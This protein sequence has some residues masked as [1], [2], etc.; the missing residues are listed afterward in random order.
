[1]IALCVLWTNTCTHTMFLK[2][3]VR[4]LFIFGTFEFHSRIQINEAEFDN[5]FVQ[6][7]VGTRNCIFFLLWSRPMGS[8]NLA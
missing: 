4:V 7:E 2:V 8:V 6:N 5:I 1:M 3:K